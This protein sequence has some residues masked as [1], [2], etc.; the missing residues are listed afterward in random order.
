MEMMSSFSLSNQVPRP[1]SAR[2][3]DW[4]F[5]AVGEARARTESTKSSPSSFF[6]SLRFPQVLELLH[7][8]TYVAI[9]QIPLLFLDWYYHSR[10]YVFGTLNFYLPGLHLGYVHEKVP[11]MDGCSYANLPSRPP[12]ESFDQLN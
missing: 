9:N 4:S 5:A 7:F 8:Y 10:A 1:M 11:V 3:P 2:V 12:L 6:L